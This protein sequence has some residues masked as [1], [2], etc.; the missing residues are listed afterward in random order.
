VAFSDAA[1]MELPAGFFGSSSSMSHGTGK[2]VLQLAALS[3]R[4]KG[5]GNG[6]V[7]VLEQA[8]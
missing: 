5:T 2:C 7:I 4:F 1:F 6:K 8:H 3:V